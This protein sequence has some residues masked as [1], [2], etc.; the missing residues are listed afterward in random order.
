MD[1]NQVI[2]MGQSITINPNLTSRDPYEVYHLPD[3]RLNTHQPS[4][5][6]RA[7]F[8]TTHISLYIL[9]LLSRLGSLGCF[10]IYTFL[11]VPD[12]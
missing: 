9:S 11:S 3:L 4:F 5:K 6:L 1:I 7:S 12:R 2:V 10:Y 8:I